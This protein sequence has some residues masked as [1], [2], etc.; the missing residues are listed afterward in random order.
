M[1]TAA[2]TLTSNNGLWH[3]T[4]SIYLTFSCLSTELPRHYNTITPTAVAGGSRQRVTK[5]PG[6]LPA[7]MCHTPSVTTAR[8]RHRQ[9]ARRRMGERCFLVWMDCQSIARRRALIAVEAW[10]EPSGEN[11]R[12]DLNKQGRRRWPGWPRDSAAGVLTE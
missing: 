6:R 7:C 8:R 12:Q 11:L 1:K 2:S 10:W 9:T 4:S 5:R 3:M